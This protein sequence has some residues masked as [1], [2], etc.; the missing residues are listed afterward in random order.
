MLAHY[1][2]N[3]SSQAVFNDDMRKLFTDEVMGQLIKNGLF[4]FSFM[5]DEIINASE[6]SYQLV[7]NGIIKY[8]K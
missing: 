8:G 7:K 5:D 4:A 6:I 3:N 1:K 2:P